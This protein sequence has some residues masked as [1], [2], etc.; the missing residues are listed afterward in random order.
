MVRITWHNLEFGYSKILYK[1]GVR[2]PYVLQISFTNS[3]LIT[4]VKQI[5]YLNVK[6][7]KAK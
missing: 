3:R 6:Y 7:R 4:K 5:Y 1:D 2:Y